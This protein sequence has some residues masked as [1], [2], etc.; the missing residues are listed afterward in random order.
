MVFL[1]NLY[2]KVRAD[3]TASLATGGL[4]AVTLYV[5]DAGGVDVDATTSAALIP[6]LGWLGG[7]V[8][9]YLKTENGPEGITLV[10]RPDGQV[11]GPGP[12]S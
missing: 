10:K 5:L 8:A 2:S 4:T 12:S 11:S 6:A 3:L 9:G 1:G 7:K